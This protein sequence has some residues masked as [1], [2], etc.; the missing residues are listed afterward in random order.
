M[1]YADLKSNIFLFIELILKLISS[2]YCCSTLYI[3]FPFGMNLLTSAFALSFVPLYNEQ[4]GSH[5]YSFTFI[6]FAVIPNA[7]NSLPLSTVIDFT[8]IS[9]SSIYFLISLSI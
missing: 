6:L 1:S 3:D 9:F 2:K 4:Y 5:L 7:S 8:S